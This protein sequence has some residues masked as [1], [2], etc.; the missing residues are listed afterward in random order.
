[1]AKNKKNL[2][3]ETVKKFI[4]P[5]DETGKFLKS[6]NKIIGDFKKINSQEI[7]EIG[8]VAECSN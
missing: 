1:M 5:S 2:I 6:D 7:T 4:I 8:Q 3:N